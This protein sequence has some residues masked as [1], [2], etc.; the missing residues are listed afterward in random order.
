MDRPK[1][2]FLLNRCKPAEYV[3][4]TKTMKDGSYKTWNTVI[5]YDCKM[6]W[7]S[8]SSTYVPGTPAPT[9]NS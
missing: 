1:L 7:C 4:K 6:S 9:S 5:S 8:T 2:I 3:T